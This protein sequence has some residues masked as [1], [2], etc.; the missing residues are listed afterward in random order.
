MN[1]YGGCISR[2][3]SIT[4][5]SLDGLLGNLGVNLFLMF[6]SK[7]SRKNVPK[8]KLINIGVFVSNCSSLLHIL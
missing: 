6:I 4:T 3:I 8:S 7:S 5:S 2:R 1:S